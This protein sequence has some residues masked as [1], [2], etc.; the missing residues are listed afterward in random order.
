MAWMSRAQA[1]IAAGTQT[2][3]RG[4]RFFRDGSF[5][6]RG[7]AA[8]A[9]VG[10]AGL[11]T[12][13]GCGATPVPAVTASSVP[14]GAALPPVGC[15]VV[16]HA[17]DTRAEGPSAALTPIERVTVRQ[18]DGAS[19]LG[20]RRIV[21]AGAVTR[22]VG[23]GFFVQ[24]PF[25]APSHAGATSSGVFVYLGRDAAPAVQPGD[26]LRL[27]ATVSAWRGARDAPADADHRASVELVGP[28]DV[29]IL[30]HG[31]TPSAT[32]ID[33]PP[34]SDA[35]AARHEG[36]VVAIAV[37]LTIQDNHL[38]ARDGA[39]TLAAGSRQRAPTDAVAPGLAAH[40][41]ANAQAR[42]RLLLDD[43][44]AHAWPAPVPWLAADGRGRDG[45]IVDGLAG[46][47]DLGP[48]VAS[49]G[50]ARAWRLRPTVPVHL[51]AA[52][53]RPARPPA[54]GGDARVASVNVQNFFLSP[55][56]GRPACAPR[57]VAADCRGARDAAE[58]E[59]QRAKL[60]VMLSA[61]DADVIALMELQNDRDAA[62]LSIAQALNAR[63]GA[64]VWAPVLGAP[65]GRDAIRVGMVY[66]TDRVRPLGAAKIDADVAHARPPVAQVFQWPGGAR[67]AVIASHFKSKRCE[68]A[69]AAGRPAAARA[70]E[71]PVE[72]DP[73][74]RAVAAAAADDTA[75]ATADGAAPWP[76]ASLLDADLHDGQACWNARR[77][78]E[79]NALH[80]FATTFARE[81]G[82][83]DV[84][85]V[86]DFNAYAREDPLEALRRAGWVDLL[87]RTASAS[88]APF[89]YSFVHDGLA[90]RL[91]H[92]FASP[93][94]A[95]RVT[96]AA[97]WHVDADEPDAIDYRLAHRAPACARCA[98]DAFDAR[99]PYR[100]SDHDPLVV[101]LRLGPAV[102]AVGPAQ[103]ASGPRRQ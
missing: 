70:S 94:L 74:D 51:V 82:G 57:G 3:P 8:A 28:A 95:P 52:N 79:A 41:L 11:A 29:R 30:G 71:P 2:S 12:L 23:D 84:L 54:V 37:P 86:G 14:G 50:G 53:P 83:V 58:F 39:L 72:A 6:G 34:A 5:V 40:Q 44:D 87:D 68:G 46:V 38:V 85:L 48:A 7:A 1:S 55:A 45:D 15:D 90:G 26:V 19:V 42:A 59:R 75:E 73:R 69:A 78:T 24:D 61:L 62:A 64:F 17:A 33:W 77:V 101:G 36:M 88:P 32:P 100:A 20:G 35:D 31:C 13:G 93:D 60:A 80:R 98:P 103:A 81:H 63:A 49:A 65:G 56:D 25:P 97:E 91:D 21:T 47:L 10:F 9:L 102:A 66:R 89:P 22:V 67:I 76:P 96:G 92:A 99:T 43:G 27:A 18:P 16:R 4:L